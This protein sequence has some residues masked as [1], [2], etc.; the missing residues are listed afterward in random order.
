[1]N[2]LATLQ[3]ANVSVIILNLLLKYNYVIYTINERFY[4]GLLSKLSVSVSNGKIKRLTLEPWLKL[5]TKSSEI[6]N[7]RIK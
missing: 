1:M 3:G 7:V 6:E 2:G 4:S 5:Y